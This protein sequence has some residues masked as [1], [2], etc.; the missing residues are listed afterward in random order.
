MKITNKTLSPDVV[1][2]FTTLTKE[3]KIPDPPKNLQEIYILSRIAE[4]MG[5]RAEKDWSVETIQS[6]PEKDRKLGVQNPN[7]SAYVTLVKGVCKTFS[8]PDF[9][10]LVKWLQNFLSSIGKTADFEIYRTTNYVVDIRHSY[11]LSECLTFV[12]SFSMQKLKKVVS[13]LE[14]KKVKLKELDE[15]REKLA[16]WESALATST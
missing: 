3:F 5:L 7:Y 10:A 16:A 4:I 12:A 2:K 15:A 8:F 13:D 14:E 1:A 6:I 11:T 9:T